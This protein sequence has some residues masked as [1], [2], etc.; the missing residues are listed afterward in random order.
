[1]PGR[2]AHGKRRNFLGSTSE[3]PMNS[4]TRFVLENACPASGGIQI[5]HAVGPVRRPPS[6]SGCETSMTSHDS[7]I[8]GDTTSTTPVPRTH[9]RPGL[10]IGLSPFGRPDAG[11]VAAVTRAGGLGVLDLGGPGDRARAELA[12]LDD[13]APGPWGVRVSRACE[14]PPAAL[15]AVADGM[16][17]VVLGADL[18]H[19]PADGAWRSADL[20]A[21]YRVL[22]EVT[23][24]EEAVAAVDGGA[25][26]LVAVGCEAAGP[27]GELTSFVLLQRV[28]AA[29]LGV[30]VWVR[31]GIGTYTAPAAV[32]GGAAGVVLD[33]QLSLL[34][35]ADAAAD[36]AT[37]GCRPDG[38]TA[39]VAGYRVQ[40]PPA[41]R[42]GAD[43]L[44][45]LSALDVLERMRIRPQRSAFTPLGQDGFL[46]GAFARRFGTVAR[47][48]RGVR[49][50]VAGARCGELADAARAVLS[51]DSPW[52]TS[53][54][55]RR[56]VMQG[57]MTRVS[58]TPAFALAVARDGALPC[59]ALALADRA[60]TTRMLHET[61]RLLGERPWG[62]GILG[63]APE[64]VRAAQLDAIREVRPP[65]VV[66]AG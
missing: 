10:V 51:A 47:A 6:H 8:S 43:E 56:P 34:A 53:S 63:F 7:R 36:I 14:V 57:P 27:V 52:C 24:V 1:M 49:A 22:A 13:R 23:S 21:R 15:D 55:L 16:D 44:R 58:D 26:G 50:A 4:S 41:A 39:V 17:V 45:A 66:I 32:L 42:I 18:A 35:E 30:P 11:L 25:A 54:G 48:V 37:A 20:R 3:F 65:V 28:L 5:P 59:L 60:T 12:R 9:G 2:I 38:E 64:D 19:E 29:D 33:V 62:A 46:A 61:A 31:G 40:I